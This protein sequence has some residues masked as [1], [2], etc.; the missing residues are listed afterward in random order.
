MSAQ[1]SQAATE[2][3]HR[4]DAQTVQLGTASEVMEPSGSIVTGP[5]ELT[6]AMNTIGNASHA[7]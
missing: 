1:V 3:T 2:V 5:S 4:K 7:N 6:G